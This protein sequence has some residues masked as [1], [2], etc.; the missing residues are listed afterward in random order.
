MALRISHLVV[1]FC[2]PA[3][4]AAG[5]VN[6]SWQVL[7]QSL[8]PGKS[9]VVKCMNSAQFEGKLLKI[10]DDSITVQSHGQPQVIRRDEV[11]RVR[12][13]NIRR[14]NT[15]LGLAVGAGGGAALGGAAATRQDFVSAGAVVGVTTL[16]GVGVGA[17]VGGALPIG[18]PLYEAEKPVKPSR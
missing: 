4:V 8:Q 14:R 15:L 17:A 10:A 12:R 16:L 2:L 11:F 6:R 7:T 18:E 5:E 9:V 3:L 13:A 1:S